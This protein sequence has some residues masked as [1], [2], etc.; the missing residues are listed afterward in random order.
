MKE[1]GNCPM[2]CTP[3]TA[4]PE[5]EVLDRPGLPRQEN[6]IMRWA[7]RPQAGLTSTQQTAADR[8]CR[9]RSADPGVAVGQAPTYHN[10]AQ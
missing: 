9:R 7:L 1:G 4:V 3:I 6:A 8:A 2:H 10:D 5:S